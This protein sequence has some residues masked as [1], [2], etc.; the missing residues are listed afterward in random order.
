MQQDNCLSLGYYSDSRSG[1]IE[2]DAGISELIYL[3]YFCMRSI[4]K[5]FNKL[6][7]T[8]AA[9]G[10]LAPIAI[11]AGSASEFETTT[12][13]SGTTT[14][15]VGATDFEQGVANS[16]S[17]VISKYAVD[18]TV[19]TSFT[20]EDSLV[21]GFE[22]GNDDANNKM[23][24]TSSVIGNGSLNIHSL[25]Y[26]FPIGD[27]FT[28]AAGPLLDQDDL[29][30]TTLS[31]YSNTGTLDAYL[32]EPGGIATH[33]LTGSGAAIAFNNEKGFNASVNV[34]STLGANS[35]QGMFTSEG[36]DIVTLSAGYDSSNAGFG[37][38]YSKID[39]PTSLLETYDGNISDL[40]GTTF[41]DSH[42]VAVGGYWN[43]T[44]SADVSAAITHINPGVSGTDNGQTFAVG[45]DYEVGPGTI[46]VGAST[47]PEWNLTTGDY[48]QAGNM[49]EVY[50]E[51]PVA[52]SIK[53]KPLLQ[54]TG[55]DSDWVDQNIY[56]IETQFSF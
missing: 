38:I 3:H 8:P 24:T 37:V 20:G 22:T 7:L 1:L 17:A 49:Y 26:Q 19:N 16:G 50:Y 51:F 47:Y 18:F 39:D 41:D 56:A 42:I 5:S 11:S 10:L 28:V 35:T 4:M 21:A 53:V 13:V 9:L 46:S 43:I 36:L 6:F 55:L 12:K 34:I 44:E 15:I 30:P 40:L 33:G 25:Y 32:M 52:D 27:N 48:S 45:V 23:A 14:F 31:T 54:V 29:I 2:K